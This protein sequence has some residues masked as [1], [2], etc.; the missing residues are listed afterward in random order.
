VSDIGK[1]KA[2]YP[3]WTQRFDLHSLLQD[4][5]DHNVERWLATTTS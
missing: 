2:H 1:F 4:I 5:H 3:A